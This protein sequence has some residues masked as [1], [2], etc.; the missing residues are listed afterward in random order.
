MSL[1]LPH[2]FWCSTAASLLVFNCSFAIT[3]L[4]LLA[5]VVRRFG[6]KIVVDPELRMRVA[7]KWELPSAGAAYALGL[8]IDKII[9]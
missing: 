6:V 5:T 7:K 4:I 8:W 9:M 1:S 2:F 3:N